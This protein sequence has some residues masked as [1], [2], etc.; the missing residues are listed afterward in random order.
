MHGLIIF[1][2]GCL[3]GIVIGVLIMCLFRVNHLHE[4]NFNGKDDNE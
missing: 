1:I 2:I 3:I 4:K